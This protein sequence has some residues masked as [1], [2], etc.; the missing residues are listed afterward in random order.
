MQPPYR[1]SLVGSQSDAATSPRFREVLRLS[2]Y[3]SSDD[4]LVDLIREVIR[5]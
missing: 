2:T 4:N 5:R 3:A 1:E